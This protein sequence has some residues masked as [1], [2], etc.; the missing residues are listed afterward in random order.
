[1]TEDRWPRTKNHV[2]DT[3][4]V[5]V[6]P[7]TG[8]LLHVQRPPVRA[9]DTFEQA[10]HDQTTRVMQEIVDHMN[11]RIRLRI[12][13]SDLADATNPKMLEKYPHLGRPEYIEHLKA[14]IKA[15]EE[16]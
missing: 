10:H 9:G 3:E 15:L 16:K 7:K 1:M 14:L 12:L 6:S 4:L 8:L 11:D 2:T 5:L 13:R